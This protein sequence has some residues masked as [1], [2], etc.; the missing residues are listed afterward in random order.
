MA[1]LLFWNTLS[2]SASW[3]S[4]TLGEQVTPK[5][6]IQKILDRPQRAGIALPTIVKALIPKGTEFAKAILMPN[7][8]DAAK[9]SPLHSMMTPM[10]GDLG[11]KG[12]RYSSTAL[13]IDS[14]SLYPENLAELIVRNSIEITGF[15]LG[16]LG[17]KHLETELGVLL[18]VNTRLKLTLDDCGINRDELLALANQ[19]SAS[20]IV[21]AGDAQAAAEPLQEQTETKAEPVP[22]APTEQSVD[23]EFAGWFDG[24][25]YEQLAAMFKEHSEPIENE[26]VWHSYANEAHKNGLKA[27]RVS[28]GKFNPYKAGLWWLYRKE[29]TGWTLARLNRTLANN[30]PARSK[31][32]E[33]RLTGDD[34][35]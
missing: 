20:G 1:E 5:S 21:Q 18:P 3:L 34:Y 13:P 9:Y 30:L 31:E 15:N 32:H 2:E 25:G 33:P 24:V 17:L 11:V 19:L 7:D 14:I 10:H 28:R 27:A 8:E 22:V 4:E 12:A 26:N 35:K 16:Q 23:D 29:P 6:L